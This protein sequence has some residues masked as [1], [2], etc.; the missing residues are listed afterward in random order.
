MPA[1]N[2]RGP[3]DPRLQAYVSCLPSGS[4]IE[5]RGRG[6]KTNKGA[7]LRLPQTDEPP[8]SVYVLHEKIEIRIDIRQVV[9]P[10]PLMN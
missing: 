4:M 6:N 5:W 1:L 3:V 8:R 2:S 9:R 10:F 7:F